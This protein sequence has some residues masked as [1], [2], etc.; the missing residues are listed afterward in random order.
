MENKYNRVFSNITI[1]HA[2]T[3]V[4]LEEFN[5]EFEMKSFDFTAPDIEDR[6]TYIPN[7]D[8][9]ATKIYIDYGSANQIYLGEVSDL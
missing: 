7:K 9:T 5:G 4:P 3:V 1:S 2:G 8:N 6:I